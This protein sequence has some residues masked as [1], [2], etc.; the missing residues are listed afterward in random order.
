MPE[1]KSTFDRLKV[2]VEFQGHTFPEG[3]PLRTF[4]EGLGMKRGTPSMRRF[5]SLGQMVLEPGDP[6][7]VAPHF[8]QRPLKFPA[9]GDQTGA[10][11]LVVTTMGDMNVPASSGLCRPGGGIRAVLG[12]GP[13]L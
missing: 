9:V 11:T 4:A 2:E 1:P 6:A 13:R 8:T 3:T 7:S 10:H 12:G 5:M